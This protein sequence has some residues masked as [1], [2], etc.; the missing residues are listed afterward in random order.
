MLDV[1]ANEEAKN[2]MHQASGKKMLP[3]IFVDG[4]FKGFREEF[5]ILG[6]IQDEANEVGEAMVWLGL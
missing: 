4:K 2:F 3:Q 5:G 6:L 1:A